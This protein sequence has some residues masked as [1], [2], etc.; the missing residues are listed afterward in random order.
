ME[1]TVKFTDVLPYDN[2]IVK[3]V[4]KYFISN[5]NFEFN[6]IPI[7][8]DSLVIYDHNVG[9]V[10]INQLPFYGLGKTILNKLPKTE[11]GF[12]FKVDKVSNN[13]NEQLEFPSDLDLYWNM[14]HFEGLLDYSNQ[15][16]LS[17]NAATL[18]YNNI[19]FSS[20]AYTFDIDSLELTNFIAAEE[21]TINCG[22]LIIKLPPLTLVSKHLFKNR[23]CKYDLNYLSSES[24]SFKGFD[25]S[26]LSEINNENEFKFKFDIDTQVKLLNHPTYNTL[27]CQRMVNELFYTSEGDFLILLYD[28]DK[29]GKVKGSEKYKFIKG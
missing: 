7:L 10:Y 3:G 5:E 20:A 22:E 17:N 23:T 28:F 6:G 4:S 1:C 29:N 25:I 13:K 9:E 21:Y 27:L 14:N 26:R 16:D 15:V 18:D 11:D 2:K 8:K 12:T 24:F 19:K